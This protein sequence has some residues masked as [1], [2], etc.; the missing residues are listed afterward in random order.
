MKTILVTPEQALEYWPTLS[1]YLKESLDHGVGEST[2]MDYFKKIINYQAQLWVFMTD[3]NEIKG[4]GLTQFLEYSTHKTLH[5][6]GAAGVNWS[7]WADQYYIVERFAKDNGCKAVEQWGRAG[8][9]KILPKV[10]PGFET[11][12]HVMRKEIGE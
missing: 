4:V 1:P 6:I 2:L 12:Y 10:I 8:W 5:I 7:E 3:E 11:V 9:T